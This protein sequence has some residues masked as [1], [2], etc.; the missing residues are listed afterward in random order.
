[1]SVRSQLLFVLGSA[2][3]LAACT[4]SLSAQNPPRGAH[5]PG[6]DKK[7]QGER[8]HGKGVLESVKSDQ[9]TLTT[10]DGQSLVLKFQKSANVHV[11]G[12]VTPEE[13][14]R[15]KTVQFNAMFDKKTRRIKDPV[16]KLTIFTPSKDQPAG[17]IPDTAAKTDDDSIDL[18][19][20]WKPCI[21]GG[22]IQ[23]FAGQKLSINVP[24][25]T[26]SRLKVDLADDFQVNV[27]VSDLHLV[28]AGDKID[29]RKAVKSDDDVVHVMEA[30]IRL[31][32]PK[33]AESQ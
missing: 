24:G 20:N 30:T 15:G 12:T 6:Q 5:Q 21:I 11:V 4:T 10:T 13:L 14:H 16:K 29:V 8:F 31:A 9:M 19:A 17:V 23:T 18:H 25:L 7:P 33:K 32:K 26:P 2:A 22:S 1:M 28:K 27:D 3:M